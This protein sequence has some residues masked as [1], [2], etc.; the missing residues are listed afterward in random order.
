MFPHQME[1]SLITRASSSAAN[2]RFSAGRRA[3]VARSRCWSM[4][5]RLPSRTL[6]FASPASAH[7]PDHSLIA[8]AVD[9][10]GS[11]FYAV[12][13]IEAATGH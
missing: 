2:I 12:N 3:K 9:T 8:Y 11:E 10:K 1:P 7:S 13:V 4:A 6:I 5:M